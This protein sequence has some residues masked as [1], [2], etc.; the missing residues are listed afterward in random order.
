MISQ[1]PGKSRRVGRGGPAVIVVAELPDSR[2]LRHAGNEL[3]GDQPGR[4]QRRCVVPRV[5]RRESDQDDNRSIVE[6]RLRFE[7]QAQ[8]RFERQPSQDGEHR[9]RAGPGAEASGGL[10]VPPQARRPAAN[11]STAAE[12]GERVDTREIIRVATSREAL[13]GGPFS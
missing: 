6:P 8:P 11:R 1:R 10:P 9:C 12:A 4:R 2:G 7:R 13:P 3:V 5:R